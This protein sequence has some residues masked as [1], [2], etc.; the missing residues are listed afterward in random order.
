MKSPFEQASGADFS[1]LPQALKTFHA[2]TSLR[3]FCGQADVAYGTGFVTRLG[4]RSGSFP[5]QGSDVAVQIKVTQ[6][7]DTEHWE[8]DFDGHIM[9]S[10]LKFDT[11]S[12]LVFERIGPLCCGLKIKLEDA[13]I[14]VTFKWLWV[15]GLPVPTRLLPSS[16]SWEW[17]DESGAFCFDIAAELLWRA[18]F[19][20]YHGRLLTQL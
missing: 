1:D 20:R 12:G 15:M 2:G 7:G 3:V 19:I 17:Q 14:S 5:P 8:R 10:S 4:L 16:T 9:A 13:R 18:P 11:A 6:D